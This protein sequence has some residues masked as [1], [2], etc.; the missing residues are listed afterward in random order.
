MF[1]HIHSCIILN[2]CSALFGSQHIFYYYLDNR[3][4]LHR[5][6]LKK[7]SQ[8]HQHHSRVATAIDSA[9]NRSLFQI[10]TNGYA[11]FGLNFDSRYPGVLN[12]Y[13][14]G[15]QKRLQAERQ[16]FAMLAPMWT[17]NNAQ[18]GDIYYRI[19]DLTTPGSTYFD[20]LRTKVLHIR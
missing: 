8:K 20:K 10:Y 18:Y 15:Y 6:F 17:D 11:T 5:S 4:A 12:R 3:R 1:P 2:V 13:M 7:R 9:L 14:L 16:G 19:Y